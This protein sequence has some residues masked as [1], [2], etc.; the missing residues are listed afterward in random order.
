MRDG[1]R[2]GGIPENEVHPP[3]LA[4]RGGVGHYCRPYV[5]PPLW[6]YRKLYGIDYGTP[7]IDWHWVLARGEYRARGKHWIRGVELPLGTLWES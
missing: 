1:K 7:R 4:L 5:A 6:D 3:N 2:L